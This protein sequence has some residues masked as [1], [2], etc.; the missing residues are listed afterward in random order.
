MIEIEAISQVSGASLQ[1]QAPISYDEIEFDE[2]IGKPESADLESFETALEQSNVNDFEIDIEGDVVF[3]GTER[4]NTVLDGMTDN[5]THHMS[6]V[7]ENMDVN[8]AEMQRASKEMKN[9]GDL[10]S[11]ARTGADLGLDIAT[12]TLHIGST[13]KVVQYQEQMLKQQ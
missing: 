10:F 1:D 8:Y 12:A 3:K 2:I 13:D 6:G 7:G 5:F 4:T 11:L 9:L